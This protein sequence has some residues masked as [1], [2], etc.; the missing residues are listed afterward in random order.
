MEVRDFG[1]KVLGAGSRVPLPCGRS[2][3]ANG[4]ASE[5]SRPPALPV[6][7]PASA[8]QVMMSWHTLITVKDAVV[9]I[10]ADGQNDLSR[11]NP[12][13]AGFYKHTEVRQPP[14]TSQ[15]INQLV[16]ESTGCVEGVRNLQPE[17]SRHTLLTF[18][19]VNTVNTKVA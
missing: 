15:P 17:G 8:R 5:T 18:F 19:K 10:S 2:A 11:R 16:D 12:R 13:Q 9:T 7:L 4:R 3:P 1:L 6:S 14:R